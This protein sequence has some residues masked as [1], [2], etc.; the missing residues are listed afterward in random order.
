MGFMEA[1]A[2]LLRFRIVS[3]GPRRRNVYG[4]CTGTPKVSQPLCRIR[5][6][7][8]GGIE[9]DPMKQRHRRRPGAAGGDASVDDEGV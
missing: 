6:I 9:D 2:S 3:P 1:A 8:Q 4:V 5:E 7:R